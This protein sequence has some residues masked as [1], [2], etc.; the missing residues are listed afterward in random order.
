MRGQC[1]ARLFLKEAAMK[2]WAILVV[3]LYFL[4]LVGLTVPLGLVALYPEATLQGMVEAYSEWLYWVF[5]VLMVAAQATLLLVPIDLSLQRPTT[6]RSV[7]W[8]V[9]SA[10][11]MV[12]MLVAGAAVSVF[13]LMMKGKAIDLAGVGH[14]APLHVVIL[15]VWAVWT[16]VF[17]RTSRD[18]AADVVSRQCRYLLKGSILELLIA[19]PTHVVV[20]GR[21][22]C[23]AGYLT[24]L[25]IAFGVAVMLFSFGPGVFFLFVQRRKRLQPRPVEDTSQ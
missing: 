17:Y 7:L 11:L 22:Y 25:G 16:L 8:P 21:D 9:L 15:A 18:P 19:V 23:C 5:V 13:E 24:L 20:R 3:L 2:R 14:G 4:I 12:G 10:G 6:H 1:T